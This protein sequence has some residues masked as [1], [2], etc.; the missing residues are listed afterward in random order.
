MKKYDDIVVGSGV[1]GLAMALILGMN[2]RR[3]LLLEKNP[4]I[5][6][7]VSRFYS[8]YSSLKIMPTA[9][10]LNRKTGFMKYPT[11]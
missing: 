4:R 6:G 10:I 11:A 2:G 7:S 5:G 1:S 9:F 3:V 8:R